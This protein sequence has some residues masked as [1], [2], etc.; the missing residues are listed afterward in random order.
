MGK[1]IFMSDA[2]ED[3]EQIPVGL[4]EAILVRIEMTGFNTHGECT[5]NLRANFG[6]DVLG[7]NR[8]R[9]RPIVMKVT[10]G[11]NEGRYFVARSGRAPAIVDALTGQREMEAK[12]GRRM[13]FCVIGDFRKPR[14][15]N[16]E[17]GGIDAARFERPDG[18]GVDGVGHADVVAVDNEQLR[19]T[20]IAEFFLERLGGLL[21]GGRIQKESAGQNEKKRDLFHEEKTFRKR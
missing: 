19:F 21:G 10:V 6:F 18:G 1:I 2:Q 8:S 12:I 7:I 15:R 4:E 3:F 16:H 17:A 11:V 9:G 13:S 5:S 20:R 14:A